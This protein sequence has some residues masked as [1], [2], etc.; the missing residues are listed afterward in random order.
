MT[1]ITTRPPVG[2]P[3]TVAEVKAHLRLS[4]ASDDAQIGALVAA[5]RETV[6]REAQVAMIER[7][8]RLVLD[9]LPMSGRTT[10]PVHPVTQV[11]AVT[12]YDGDGNPS[13]YPLAGLVLDGFAVPPRL[14][15]RQAPIPGRCVNG[16]EIDFDAGFGESGTDV[17]NMLRRAVILLAAHWYE[18]RADFRASDQPVSYPAGYAAM[19]APWRRVRLS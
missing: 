15:F 10:L 2:E 18:F 8:Y 6:E 3:V 5:A 19:I 12:M 11:T 14:V 9:A 16:I 4:H 17:P 1:L 13:V 7:G